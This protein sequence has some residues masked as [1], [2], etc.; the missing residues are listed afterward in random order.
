M[1]TVSNKIIQAAAGNNGGEVTG[2]LIEVA[3]S[4]SSGVLLSSAPQAGDLLIAGVGSYNGTF[5]YPSGF[6]S[7]QYHRSANWSNSSASY[8]ESVRVFYKIAT[9]TEGTYMAIGGS[10]SSA[11][12]VYRFNSPVT[13]VTKLNSTA[14]SGSVNRTQTVAMQANYTTYP[15]I[16][17]CA[18]GAYNQTSLSMTNQDFSNK[19]RTVY[20]A[21]TL[22]PVDHTPVVN[23][24][25]GSG[26]FN[27][28]CVYAVI[29][30]NFD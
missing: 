6:T 2:E 26:S 3:G 24:I 22:R 1:S 5:G 11:L 14:Q 9:G 21:A 23:Y 13:S 18:V 16:Y 7:L 27:E 12:A 25:S 10:R 8:Y 17:V 19:Y 20:M 29:A 30:P 4:D 15:Q 28:A